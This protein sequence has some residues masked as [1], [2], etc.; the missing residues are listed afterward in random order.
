M[1]GK[2][3][4]K[5]KADVAK[6]LGIPEGAEDMF[7]VYM[8]EHGNQQIRLKDGAKTIKV[9]DT[10][11]ELITDPITGKQILKMITKQDVGKETL[12]DI[13]RLAGKID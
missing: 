10:T 6:K 9:G 4:Y 11:Y 8:D 1:T 7:E 2:K 12:E 3:K 13:L 5:L